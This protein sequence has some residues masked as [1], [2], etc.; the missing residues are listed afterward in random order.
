MCFYE[1]RECIISNF[2][3]PYLGD[4]DTL[5]KENQSN[6]KK[7]ARHF[8]K[9]SYNRVVFLEELFQEGNIGLYEAYKKYNPSNADGVNVKFWSYAR[10][11]VRGRMIDFI[12]KQSNLIRPSKNVELITLKIKKMNLSNLPP[13]EISARLKCSKNLVEQAIDF[14]K[15]K[16]VDSLN[17]PI[18]EARELSDMLINV[19]D[20]PEVHDFWEQLCSNESLFLKYKM[21]GFHLKE[22]QKKLSI[23]ESEVSEINETIKQKAR[24]FFNLSK[25]DKGVDT[26]AVNKTSGILTKAEYLKQ[27]NKKII[28]K[29]ICKKYGI[30]KSTLIKYKVSWGIDT[31]RKPK[32]KDKEFSVA[33]SPQPLNPEVTYTNKTNYESKVEQLQKKVSELEVRLRESE[34]RIKIYENEQIILWKMQDILRAK[35]QMKNCSHPTYE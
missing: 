26:M 3:N 33:I 35:L 28:D 30:S 25:N 27:K 8:S 21:Q 34:E 5:L 7:L 10:H 31:P 24:L 16:N 11:R 20:F 23:D 22:I 9:L 18:G 6:I 32:V 12:G 19:T 14:L 1:G 29:E 15:I 4:F 13:T 2:F 17:R